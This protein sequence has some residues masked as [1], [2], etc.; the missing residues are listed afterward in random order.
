MPLTDRHYSREL[1]D[2]VH[3]SLHVGQGIVP[4]ELLL[5]MSKA[6]LENQAKLAALMMEF[7]DKQTDPDMKAAIQELHDM[8]V[9]MSNLVDETLKQ[10]DAM[11][12]A[13]DKAEALIEQGQEDGRMVM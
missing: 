3:M 6:N 13:Y 7:K 8:G 4:G 12:P 10:V 5:Q 11:K 2:N 9:K 1:W